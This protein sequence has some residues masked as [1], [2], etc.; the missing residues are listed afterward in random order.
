MQNAASALRLSLEVWGKD[1]L[2]I[3]QDN[4]TVHM[5]LLL[6]GQLHVLWNLKVA[7]TVEFGVD[8]DGASV[9]LEAVDTLVLDDRVKLLPVSGAIVVPV[10]HMLPLVP[11]T[12]FYIAQLTS[13]RVVNVRENEKTN[14]RGVLGLGLGLC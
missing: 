6:V 10:Y 11:S 3:A 7:G 1:L 2:H 14:L 4:Q 8:E 12:F 5:A 9:V 13:T